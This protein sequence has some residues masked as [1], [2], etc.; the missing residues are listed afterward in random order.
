MQSQKKESD[1]N[2]LFNQKNISLNY[3]SINEV[4]LFK[5]INTYWKIKFGLKCC[6]YRPMNKLGLIEFIHKM[7]EIMNK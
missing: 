5:K 6:I 7:K 1:P 2:W 3:Y 4:H